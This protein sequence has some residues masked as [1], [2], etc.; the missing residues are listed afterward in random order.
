MLL[1]KL[2][3]DRSFR[4]AFLLTI[5][6]FGTGIVFLFLDLVYYGWALFILLPIVLGISIGAMP[7]PRNSLIGAIIAAVL[8]L[9]A[10]YVPGLSGLICIV[11]TLP[12]VVPLIFA[13][14]VLTHLFRR[15]DEIK[16]S[17]K[18]PVLLLPLILFVIA[19]PAERY[20]GPDPEVVREVRTD[21]ILPYRPELVYDAIKS[22]DTLD[23]E[24]PFLM[25]L[26]LPVPVKC[27]LEDE[28]VGGIRTCFFKSGRLSYRDFGSGTITERITQL[29][30]GKI[31]K[32]KVLSYNLVGRKWLGFKDAIYTFDAVGD[33]A[34]RITRITTYTSVLAPR[35]Y[36]EP[37]EKLGIRQEHAYVFNNLAKDLKRKYANLSKN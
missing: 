17:D 16:G 12:I 3:K 27:I 35:A 37:L 20:Y 6:F 36:W 33:S 15:Y 34:C 9:L 24:K 29:E 30:R 10:L 32:M 25:T 19:G 7:K 1:K 14:Y 2:I 21:K 31:L 5:I 8:F 26:D 18:L 11:M 4:L 28:G 22:V 13:G 23:A